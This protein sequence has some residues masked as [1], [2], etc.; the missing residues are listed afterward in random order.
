MEKLVVESPAKLNL[1]LNIVRKR[2]DGYH[3]LETIFIPISLSDKIIFSKSNELNLQ[4]NSD[5]LNKLDDNLILRAIKLLEEY[6][7]KKI[8]LNI[9]IEKNIPIGGGLGGG[10]SDAA[11]TL[12]TVNK[13]FDLR[14][15]FLKLSEL[16]LQL[17]SDVPFFLNPVPSYAE[18]RGE[19]LFPLSVE[20]PYPILI[21]N[22]L[23][24][25]DTAS[26]FKKI[27]PLIPKRN[28][29]KVIQEN[30]FDFSNLKEFV[31]NDFEEVIFAEYSILKKIKDELFK[32]GAEFALMSGTGSTLYGIFTNLQKALWAEDNFRQN[33]FTYLH[34]P[35]I[36]GSI[37]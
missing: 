31:T 33:Y 16:A 2:D 28:L 10:S 29:R 35:F 6:S 8:L 37:T 14:L 25:I 34:N 7:G 11:S 3:D 30:A 36:K 17:G 24:K 12:K 27:K 13:L 23:I 5:L 19:I 1:G 22:P 4:T 32:Q 9:I 18:S 21:V 15:N 26:A 20:L